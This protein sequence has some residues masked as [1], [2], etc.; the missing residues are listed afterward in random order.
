MSLSNR[1]EFIGGP[2]D[3]HRQT[4][5]S[6]EGLAETVAL[7]VNR[8]IF[9]MLSGLPAA[10]DAHTTSIAIYELEALDGSPRYYFLGTTSAAEPFAQR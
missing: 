8:N 6:P 4:V 7:P 3:G 9:R 10:G 5:P 1:V 2:Y